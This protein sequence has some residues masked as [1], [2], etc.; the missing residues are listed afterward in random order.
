MTLANTVAGAARSERD[1][2]G[3][4]YARGDD[5]SGVP[6]GG[7]RRSRGTRDRAR[8]A[9]AQVV[10]GRR[11]LPRGAA[12]G[13]VRLP[14][15]RATARRQPGALDA[16]DRSGDGQCRRGGHR[17]PQPHLVRRDG[18]AS[19]VVALRRPPCADRAFAGAVAAVEGRATRWRLPDLVVGGADRGER[20]RRRDRGQLRYAR[21]RAAGLSD[22]GSQPG[23]CRAQ[24]DRH[25]RLVPGRRR[26]NRRR[27]SRC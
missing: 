20:R 17:R 4:G 9:T 24:R 13:R 25:R 7:L 1:Y 10:P 23:A 15:R 27:A 12:A 6:A 3:A 16:V 21:R 26:W 2:Y 14:A 22:G 19:G 5:D 11:A 8:R 18:R